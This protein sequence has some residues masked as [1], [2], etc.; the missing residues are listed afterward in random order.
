MDVF[1]LFF[2]PGA[3]P[4]YWLC[5]L[6]PIALILSYYNEYAHNDQV[7]DSRFYLLGLVTSAVALAMFLHSSVLFISIRLNLNFFLQCITSCVSCALIT[8]GFHFLA[9]QSWAFSFIC[10]FYSTILYTSIYFTVMRRLPRSFTPGEGSIVTQGILIFLLT[11]ILHIYNAD[12]VTLN[13]TSKE[14]E[15]LSLKPIMMVSIK[16]GKNGNIYLKDFLYIDDAVCY[17]VP[18]IVVFTTY[19]CETFTASVTFL[20][21][22]VKFCSSSHLH[23]YQ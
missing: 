1:S 10:G 9:A 19:S 7:K 2:R 4:G 15:L 5:A 16:L 11:A 14:I 22:I 8:N 13:S 6:L 23:I 17:D 20:H 18:F 12:N 3:S 21:S